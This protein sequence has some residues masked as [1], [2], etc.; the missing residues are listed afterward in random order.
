MADKSFGVKELNLL[1]ASGTPTV[2]SP[3][4]L[5]LNANTVAISTSCTIGNNLTVTST[6]NSA[7]LNVTG[8]GTLT[9]AFATDLSVSGVTTIT[10]PANANPHSSWDVVNNS[11]SAYRFT[12]PGQDGAED[13]PNIYLVRG[14]RYVFKMNAS[15]HPFQIRVANAGAAYSDGV[16][17][18]GS[19]TGNVVFNVQH[20]A[21]AQLFY[22]CTSHGSMVGNIYIVGGPQVISG[23]VTATTFVGNLTGN[24]T[25]SGA[26]LTNLPAANLTG[27]L[28]AIS[29]A[30]LTS[31]P[32]QVTIS[33]NADNRVITG[34]SGTNLVGESTLTYSAGGMN[35][36]GDTDR[37]GIKITQSGNNYGEFN[38][39]SNRSS[40]GNALGVIRGEWNSSEVA[41]IYLTAGDDTTNKDDGQIKFFTSAAGGSITSRMEILNNGNVSIPNGNLVVASG[42][43]IDFSATGNGGSSPTGVSELFSDYETGTFTVTLANSLT[44]GTQTKLTYTKI[45]NKCHISGQ[46]RI[47]TGGSDLTINNLPFT[48]VNTGN[49]DETFSVG[50]VGLYNVSMPSD[51]NASGEIFTKTQKNDNNIYFVYNRHNNDP[52]QHT[53][54]ANG[55]YIVSHWYT[56]ST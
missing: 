50:V 40:V 23:V 45:G 48:T 8:I 56:V 3:N 41:S 52:N 12:G 44:V 28:P 15:G 55:Y 35:I 27:T 4:N 16:T 14:Q 32:S 29:G 42:H 19:Q 9:R 7:N 47:G 31:L 54:T 17:N 39:N 24:P 18:N 34:G 1:N 21:P 26:N 51:G 2:T 38:F 5:N 33:S 49:T 13:N 46:F 6:T 37:D 36:Y 10:V 22:Q 11:A 53:A 43:G 20:D 25:G 30:N